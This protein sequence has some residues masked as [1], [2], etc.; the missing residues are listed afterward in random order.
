MIRPVTVSGAETWTLRKIEEQMLE[1]AEMRTLRWIL[2]VT[3]RD[4]LIND[5]IRHKVR[6]AKVTEKIKEARL[7]WTC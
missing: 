2:G 3:L 7:H 4:R 1:C 5:E 6:V